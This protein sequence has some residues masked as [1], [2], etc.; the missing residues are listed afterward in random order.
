[1]VGAWAEGR[2]T[3]VLSP[4]RPDDRDWWFRLHL[5]LAEYAD[6]R[7]L[8][9]LG[10]EREHLLAGSV[11]GDPDFAKSCW[12][13]ARAGLDEAHHLLHPWVPVRSAQDEALAL[14][15]QWEAVFGRLGDP[16][17]QAA[18]ERVRRRLQATNRRLRRKG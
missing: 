8:R 14:Q 1:M 7:R 6:E 10:W 17:T 12:K 5:A 4:V 9:Y 3:H 13:L 18:I 16:R 15:N 11:G 2:L